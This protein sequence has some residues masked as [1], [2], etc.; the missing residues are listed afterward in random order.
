MVLFLFS[1]V[2]LLVLKMVVVE[3]LHYLPLLL[4]NG[5]LKKSEIV[6][7]NGVDVLVFVHKALIKA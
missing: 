3:V 2:K 7:D 5:I 4:V 6:R 1:S